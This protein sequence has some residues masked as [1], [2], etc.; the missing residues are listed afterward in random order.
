MHTK[1]IALWTNMRVVKWG[2]RQRGAMRRSKSKH[3]KELNTASSGQAYGLPI[4]KNKTS[5]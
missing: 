5:K 2:A 1:K 4:E 3:D